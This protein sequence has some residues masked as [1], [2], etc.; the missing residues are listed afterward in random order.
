[1]SISRGNWSN[2]SRMAQ[3]WIEDDEEEI[4]RERRR[5]NREGSTTNKVI[6][7]FPETSSSQPVPSAISPKEK[8]ELLNKEEPENFQAQNEEQ[9]EKPKQLNEGNKLTS[10]VVDK[11]KV[12]TTETQEA[13]QPR[14]TTQEKQKLT[15]T[16]EEN[17]NNDTTSNNLRNQTENITSNSQKQSISSKTQQCLEPES[18]KG[19]LHNN[20]NVRRLNQKFSS[21]KEEDHK[22]QVQ[23]AQ[24]QKASSQTDKRLEKEKTEIPVSKAQ[25]HPT[26]GKNTSGPVSGLMNTT[27]SEPLNET[28]TS[29]SHGNQSKYKTPVSVSSQPDSS[30]VSPKEKELLNKKEPENF[31]AQTGV[32]KIKVSTTETQEVKHPKSATQEKQK[33]TSAK[34]ENQN[35]GTTSNNLRNQTENITSN[36]QKQSIS[37]K[38]QQCLEPESVKGTVHNSQNVRRLNQ[39]FSSWKEE[40]HKIQVQKAQ[41]QKSSSQPDKRLEEEKAEI[42]DSKAQDHPTQGKNASGPI[43]DS[44]STTPSEPQNETNTSPSHGSQSKYKTQVFVSSVKIPRRTSSSCSIKSPVPEAIEEEPFPENKAVKS[45]V[46]VSA[47]SSS[48]LNSKQESHPSSQQTSTSFVRLG[49]LSSSVRVK[50]QQ[51]EDDKDDS[52]FTRRSSLRL[53]LRSRKIED[54]MEKYNSAIQ[55]SASVRIQPSNSRGAVVGS[56]GVANKRSIFEKDEENSEK[57]NLSRKDLTLSGSITSRI[58]Q[59]SN[60]L[61]QS[62]STVTSTKDVKTG[63][64]ATKRMLWQQKSQSSSDTKL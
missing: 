16:N 13:K 1:M 3:Q 10:T 4:I 38:N 41:V 46:F 56:D 62:S 31:Q 39:K 14:G 6:E 42:S 33:V 45:E 9:A 28:N 32:D 30:A 17:Q 47:V 64:V 34:E 36:S 19:T 35:H 21:W 27:P 29:P 12:S 63:D 24:L 37:S 7:V 26:E 15:T 5:R 20:Q 8:K 60:K 23:K 51:S 53:S 57:S 58:N 2:L 50:S 61:Q 11:I 44:V 25:D 22:I 52:G 43:S 55:R 48:N 40:D 54:R 18:V 49:P 59:W